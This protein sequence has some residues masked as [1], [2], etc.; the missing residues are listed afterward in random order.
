MI[1]AVPFFLTASGNLM[2]VEEEEV[3]PQLPKSSKSLQQ[4]A[5]PRKRS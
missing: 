5:Q 4:A 3:L 2:V 1:G